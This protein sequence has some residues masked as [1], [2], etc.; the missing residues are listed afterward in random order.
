MAV[1]RYCQENGQYHLGQR[2]GSEVTLVVLRAEVKSVPGAVATG[3]SL[4]MQNKLS[5]SLPLRVL[6]SLRTRINTKIVG[7]LCGKP[8]HIVSSL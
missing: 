2:K 8:D 5:P 3:Y 7:R 4:R 6:T 1:E